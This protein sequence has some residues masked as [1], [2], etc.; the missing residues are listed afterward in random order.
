RVAVLQRGRLVE[1]GPRDDVLRS[2]QHPYTQALLAAVP[3]LSAPKRSASVAAV[4]ALEV[5]DLQKVYKGRGFRGRATVA[6][7]DVSLVL[8]RGETLGLVGESGSG[9]STLARVV[10]RLAS[11]DSGDVII[12]GEGVTYL[13]RRELRPYR[14]RIQMIFQDPYASLDPRQRVGDI[15]AEGPLIHGADA[16]ATRKRV[17][18]L[19]ELVGLS[20]TA[21]ARYPHEFSG[22]Q[23]QRIGIARALA[24]EPEILVADE[25]VSALDVSVQAQVLQ[26]L[27]DIKTR[28]GLSMLFVTHDLR[29]ALQI[30]D[31]IAVMRAGKIVE[32]DDAAIIHA[33]PTHPYTRELFAAVPGAAWEAAYLAASARG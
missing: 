6:L 3:K 2:P 18:E 20:D 27:A 30:C 12:A 10:T 33:G 28:L 13:S 11:A 26:L 5:R 8:R 32:L 17:A 19:L 4:P 15:I 14:K 24:M 25:A 31:R 16:G 7:D 9:K 22:G 23:R 21:A 1:E 29:V